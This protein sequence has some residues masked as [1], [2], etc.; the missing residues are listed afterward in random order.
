MNHVMNHQK[1]P[2][3]MSWSDNVDMHLY[4]KFDQNITCGS[5]VGLNFLNLQA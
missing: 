5:R 3:Y 2:L 4:A 1:R